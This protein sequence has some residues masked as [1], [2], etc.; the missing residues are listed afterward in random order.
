[1]RPLFFLTALGLALTACHSKSVTAVE[2]PAATVVYQGAN[3]WTGERFERADIGIIGDRI[4]RPY[5][6]DTDTEV[7]DVSGRFITPALGNGHNHITNP[8]LMNSWLYFDIGVYYVWNPNLFS[9][10]L[11][12]ETR[13]F[14]ARPDT[15]E[16]Q[17]S[18]GGITEPKSHPEPLYVDNLGPNVYG[19]LGFEEMF[20]K[21]FHYGRTKTEISASLDR[22][23][24]QGAD[25]VKIYLL[26]SDAYSPPNADGSPTST[27]GLN[28]KNVPFLVAEAHKRG[29]P[30]I[31][32]V[33]TR[34]DV[35]VAANAGVDFL[36]HLPGYGAVS[37]QRAERVT[38][39]KEDAR[40]VSEAGMAVMPTYALAK[41]RFDAS[42]S[43]A[44]GMTE[45]ERTNLEERVER[46][47]AVQQQNLIRLR[48]A[49][50]QIVGGTDLFP[51]QL[52]VEANHWVELD[53]MS[54][55]EAAKVLFE[56]GPKLF[57]ERRIGC[58]SAGCEADFLVLAADPRISLDAFSS[59]EKRIKAGQTLVQPGETAN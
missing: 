14:Y 30:V 5:L 25:F 19:G 21:A 12:E 54:P 35:R 32:H 31:A 38:L 40:A 10:G 26:N 17:T 13:A 57:P 50:V 24:A 1:M 48:E 27:T 36:G 22:L 9:D 11:S 28:P 58:F 59:I 49:G 2:P 20:E 3:V 41:A 56:T 45:E 46:T 53:A 37:E 43:N 55:I 18:L 29:L 39:T 52:L 33:E 6:I 47:Y 15:I 7:F 23:S 42:L 44:D 51:G 16:A 8:D 4:V 34:G